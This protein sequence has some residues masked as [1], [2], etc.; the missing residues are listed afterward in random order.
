M[1][2]ETKFPVVSEMVEP[3]VA[4]IIGRLYMQIEECQKSDDYLKDHMVYDACK[5]LWTAMNS[6]N[7]LSIICNMKTPGAVHFSIAAGNEM[8]RVG[9]YLKDIIGFHPWFDKEHPDFKEFNNAWGR[10]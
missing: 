1:S 5:N 3:A 2:G 10:D 6:I 4:H 8:R 7:H 9:E